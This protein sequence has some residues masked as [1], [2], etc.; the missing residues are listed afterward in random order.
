[1]PDQIFSGDRDVLPEG[2]AVPVVSIGL[3]GPVGCQVGRLLVL[4]AILLLVIIL[5]KLTAGWPQYTVQQLH[6][7]RL[8]VVRSILATRFPSGRILA[9]RTDK[10]E[11]LFRFR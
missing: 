3:L 10:C 4:I 2:E 1:M 6:G 5:A 11:I 7:V 8:G 9:G